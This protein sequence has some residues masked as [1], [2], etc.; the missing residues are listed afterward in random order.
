MSVTATTTHGRPRRLALA[1]LTLTAT[2]GLSACQIMSP[3]T[4]NMEY[5][6]ADG[7]TVE[8]ELVEVLDLIV[9]S[10][11]NGAPGVLVG[12]LVNTDDEPVTVQFALEVDG[13]RQDLKPA[14]E[15]PAGDA[16][17][18]DGRSSDEASFTDPVKEASFTD[19]V[20]ISA[21]PAPPGSLVTV[22]VTTSADGLA[23]K[24]VPVLPP[25]DVYKAYD[26]VLQGLGTGG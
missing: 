24:L 19:P 6:P 25:D 23:S 14:V 8:T 2:F 12:Y 20:T 10:E 21:V 5:D 7:V 11:G 15:V 17:R 18:T 13:E 4:T 22:R 1:A 9:I 3:I 26:K 16:T